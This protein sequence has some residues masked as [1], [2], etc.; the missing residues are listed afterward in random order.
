MTE[1][2]T[3]SEMQVV[4]EA[5]ASLARS[6]V[7]FDDAAARGPSLLPGWSR[8]HVLTHLA[9]N[10]DGNRNMVEGAIVGEVRPQ[11]PGGAEGRAADIEAG[12]GRPVAV[13]LEDLLDSHALL[14]AAWG[15]LPADGWER[16]GDSFAFG[17]RPIR[18][19]IGS[20]LREILVHHVDLDLGFGPA[21]LP[22]AWVTRSLDWLREF[23][24]T[25]TWPGAPW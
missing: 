12:A 1:S 9:R 5:F 24:T 20:R 4:D 18:D 11:Y 19:G 6:L 25:Q 3:L 16:L 17:P 22:D 23:R 8:G 7:G 2:G 14:V 15:R 13:L 10:A 21:D